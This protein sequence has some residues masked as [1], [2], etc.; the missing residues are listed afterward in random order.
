MDAPTLVLVAVLLLGLVVLAATAILGKKLKP[1]QSRPSDWQ[2]EDA[3]RTAEL[4]SERITHQG[5]D[6]G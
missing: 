5:D 4:I 3:R 1:R 2:S 6:D